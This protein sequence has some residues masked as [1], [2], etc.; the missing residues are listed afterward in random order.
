MAGFRLL[1]KRPVLN[2]ADLSYRSYSDDH[3][4]KIAEKSVDPYLT[5]QNFTRNVWR[6]VDFTSLNSSP[7]I[8]KRTCSIA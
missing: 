1:Q 6:C 5:N 8:C 7:A 2:A 3:F 4:N